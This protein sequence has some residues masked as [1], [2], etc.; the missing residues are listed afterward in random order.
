MRPRA[1][2][3][4]LDQVIVGPI[5]GP[6]LR[7]ELDVFGWEIVVRPSLHGSRTCSWG[8]TLPLSLEWDFTALL[9]RLLTLCDFVSLL[10]CGYELISGHTFLV[11]P[12][13]ARGRPEGVGDWEL[14][15]EESRNE[16][17][18]SVAYGRMWES[19]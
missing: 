2:H 8:V 10:S 15:I 18:R 19:V 3:F 4:T 17:N 1:K 5:G 7:L 16:E 11:V 12:I 13:F 6:D 14:V 9:G